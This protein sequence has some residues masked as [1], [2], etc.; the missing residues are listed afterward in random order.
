MENISW[1]QIACLG[2]SESRVQVY[3]LEHE[4]RALT[5]PGF[6]CSQLLAR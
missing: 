4:I 5:H 1:G 6:C 2:G 3:R